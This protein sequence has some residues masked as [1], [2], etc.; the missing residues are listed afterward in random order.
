[1]NKAKIIQ[2]YEDGKISG[3]EFLK[4]RKQYH[5]NKGLK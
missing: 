3:A 4:L 1:M 5:S 2:D